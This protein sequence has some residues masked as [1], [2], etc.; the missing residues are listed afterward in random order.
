VDVHTGTAC[1]GVVADNSNVTMVGVM[2][3]IMEEGKQRSG[4]TVQANTENHTPHPSY[5]RDT[6]GIECTR[7]ELVGSAISDD[8]EC[9]KTK[10]IG[11]ARKRSHLR[12]RAAVKTL[13]HH[14]Q[15]W[16]SC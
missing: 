6:L 12:K 9:D 7:V 15:S 2:K 4:Y 5:S 11:L 3:R 14:D 13:T 1:T 16:D 10:P 8:C